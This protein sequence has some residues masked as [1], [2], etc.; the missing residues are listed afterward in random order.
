V[1]TNVRKGV[2]PTTSGIG[3]YAFLA[4]GAALMIGAIIW[5]KKSRET[6]DI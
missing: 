5:Y 1:I 4:I 3:I 6:A 2:L